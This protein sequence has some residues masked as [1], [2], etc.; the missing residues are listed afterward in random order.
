MALFHAHKSVVV[1]NMDLFSG[2]FVTIE[3]FVIFTIL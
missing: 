1:L 3:L 2:A